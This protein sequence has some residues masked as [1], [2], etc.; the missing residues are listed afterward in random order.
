M[1]K[2]SPKMIKGSTML[3]LLDTK[4]NREIYDVHN[5]TAMNGKNY[6]SVETINIGL[7]GI[8]I[9]VS[10]DSVGVPVNIR[11]VLVL[12]KLLIEKGLKTY[13]DFDTNLFDDYMFSLKRK[14]GITDLGILYEL[15]LK[16]GYSVTV[17]ASNNKCKTLSI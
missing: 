15:A 11:M 13:V 10:K 5:Q 14:R 3:P 1:Y 6:Y 9:K 2:L 7:G 12:T 8:Q 4:N 16:N 17:S